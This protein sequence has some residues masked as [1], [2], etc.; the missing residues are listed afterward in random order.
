MENR[1]KKVQQ[2]IF[3]L[4]SLMAKVTHKLYISR[5][6]DH[7]NISVFIC[8][9][10]LFT[11]LMIWNWWTGV[12]ICFFIAALP[13]GETQQRENGHKNREVNKY[14]FPLFCFGIYLFFNFHTHTFLHHQ[15]KKKNENRAS[16]YIHQIQMNGRGWEMNFTELY[17]RELRE[18]MW[19]VNDV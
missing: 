15:K 2:Y 10:H 8:R 6:R 16:I 3:F 5:S 12:D 14:F 7:V 9:T 4:V 18:N 13:L 1:E 19:K 11:Y 17:S